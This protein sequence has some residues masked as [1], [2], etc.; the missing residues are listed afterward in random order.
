[1]R[2]DT[3][4]IPR[5]KLPKFQPTL[6]AIALSP[7]C[8]QVQHLSTTSTKSEDNGHATRTEGTSGHPEDALYISLEVHTTYK[9]TL[10]SITEEASSPLV[11]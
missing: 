4:F 2:L 7:H 1:M 8:R 6:L 11:A 10:Q 3:S 5:K 9:N